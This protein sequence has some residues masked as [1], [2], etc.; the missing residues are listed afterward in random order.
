MD[1]PMVVSAVAF[2]GVLIATLGISTL[3][4][5]RPASV[6]RRLDDHV[7]RVEVVEAKRLERINVLKEPIYSTTPGLNAVLRRFRPART[8]AREL[9]HANSRMTVFQYLLI[10]L[11]LGSGLG[12]GVWLV[13]GNPL[14]AGGITVLGIAAPRISLRRRAT[15]RLK[16]FE[17]QLAEAIDLLVGSLRSGYGFLQ[18]IDSVS[19]EM[20]DPMRE[21]LVRVM[22]QSSVGIN[23]VDAL[24][25]MSE[26]INSYDLGL[27]TTAVSVQ[28][29]A[30][31]NLAEVLENLA[32]T[33]RERRRIRHEVHAL[34]TGPRVSSYILAAI[35]VVLF[36]YFMLISVEY[37]D[38][39]VG[40]LF[41]Q[42]MLGAAGVWSTIGFILSQKVSK[43]EY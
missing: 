2:V 4:S 41:G 11:L 7:V 40:S 30:G 16:A 29:Q 6:R 28:R 35:P 10:R 18:A 22:E 43:V 39:M 20:D 31:G 8:A 9:A 38:V 21:E 25:E 5:R 13:L 27:F 19:R 3:T 15:K 12:V 32:N 23:P 37:R 34:T 26:R 24:L 42:M 14:F 1:T 17:G 36:G 33:I